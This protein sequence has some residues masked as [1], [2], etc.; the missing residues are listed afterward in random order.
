MLEI[1]SDMGIVRIKTLTMP[2][3]FV[4]LTTERWALLKSVRDE[5]NAVIEDIK[6]N[7]PQFP[8]GYSG[9]MAI[10]DVWTFDVFTIQMAILSTS[11][12]LH[13]SLIHI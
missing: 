6:R 10:I 7:N 3:N 4:T 12:V 8:S 5:I 13:L 1:F 11:C 9:H 2:N